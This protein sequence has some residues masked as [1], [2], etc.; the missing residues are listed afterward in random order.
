MSLTGQT[1]IALAK[2]PS[3]NCQVV[4]SQVLAAG[5]KTP[6]SATHLLQ[7][8]PELGLR[9]AQLLLSLLDDRILFFT[10]LRKLQSSWDQKGDAGTRAPTSSVNTG[11]KQ[12]LS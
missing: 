5:Y 11:M 1:Q 9:L 7:Q 12:P 3:G 2:Y 8:G 6:R 10:P 4:H